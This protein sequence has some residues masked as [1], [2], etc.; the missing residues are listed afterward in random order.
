M[1]DLPRQDGADIV[2]RITFSVSAQRFHIHAFV[3]ASID[4]VGTRAA[5]ISP[6]SELAAFPRVAD[7]PLE[8]PIHELE[9]VRPATLQQGIIVGRQAQIQCLEAVDEQKESEKEG[10]AHDDKIEA[11][12]LAFNRPRLHRFCA[13]KMGNG[14]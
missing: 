9:V 6:E 5:G 4:D 8:V 7:L 12:R 10:R 14:V 1:H 13:L 3:K 11:L 2:Q